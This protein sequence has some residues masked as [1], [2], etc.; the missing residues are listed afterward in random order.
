MSEKVKLKI[1]PAVAVYAAAGV[2][3]AEKL[4]GLEAA[5]EMAPVDR[6]TLLFCL[7]RDKDDTVRDSASVAFTLLP[8][9]DLLGSINWSGTHPVILDAISRVHYFSPDIVGALLENPAISRQAADFLRGVALAVVANGADGGELTEDGEK[10]WSGADTEGTSQEDKYLTDEEEP[11]EEDEEYYSKFQLIQQMGISEKIKMALTG[12]KE[13]RSILINDNNKLV[14]GS[15]IRNPRITDGEIMRILKVGVQND[16]II[17]LICA[18]KEW[19]KNYQIRKALVESPKTPL[20]NAL[21]FLSTLGEKDIAG[22]A[23]SKNI[24][25]VLSTNAKRIILAKKR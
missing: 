14:S 20:P 25:S 7:M 19:I 18:N 9:E 13:W 4:A 15:V 22:Y 2:S 3:S 11:I 21:R 23:K 10:A 24:S 17:R 8:E 1:S 6:V 5:G 12:D 16:E